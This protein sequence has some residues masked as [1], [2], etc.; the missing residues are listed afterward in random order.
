MRS[1]P[2]PFAFKILK[3]PAV[4]IHSKPAT[5][6]VFAK[7]MSGGFI[8]PAAPKTMPAFPG[9]GGG[10][11]LP[12]FSA[13]AKPR[14][15]AITAALPEFANKVPKALPSQWDDSEKGGK[16]ITH[17]DTTVATFVATHKQWSG[18]VELGANGV[19]TRIGKDGGHWSISWDAQRDTDGGDKSGEL[20]LTWTNWGDEMLKTVDGGRTFRHAEYVFDLELM[21][22]VVPKWLV[23]DLTTAAPPEPEKQQRD[24]RGGGDPRGQV[25]LRAQARATSAGASASTWERGASVP[26]GESEEPARAQAVEEP[27][28]AAVT[29]SRP[30]RKKMQFAMPSRQERAAALSRRYR[31][32]GV[33]LHGGFPNAEPTEIVGFL[34][35]TIGDIHQLTTLEMKY[36]KE[37]DGV[38]STAVA[39]ACDLIGMTKESLAELRKCRLIRYLENDE[40]KRIKVL[41]PLVES[42]FA[43]IE[44][45]LHSTSAGS[46]AEVR[47]QTFKCPVRGVDLLLSMKAKYV[48]GKQFAK[49]AKKVAK[50]K[51][52]GTLDDKRIADV[53][54]AYGIEFWAKWAA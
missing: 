25:D 49:A 46:A 24:P 8:M 20:T 53:E 6:T 35:K 19:F 2:S 17:V 33:T 32:I 27:I 28:P 42:A 37:V 30:G 9:L 41:Q 40:E 1:W 23:E 4:L 51:V 13:F 21:A 7:D 18:Q 26:A 43:V 44:P 14:E 38:D 3:G 15:S 12:D 22:P 39:L 47:E 50:E 29:G 36:K 48:L 16:P 5:I 10:G 52:E 31:D 54:A 45:Y 34:K 11:G